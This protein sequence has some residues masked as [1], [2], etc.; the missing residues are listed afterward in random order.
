VG[1]AA[2]SNYIDKIDGDLFRCVSMQGQ[3]TVAVRD[4]PS[5][6]DVERGM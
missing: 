3:A 1:A 6:D 2:I 5:K 4:A